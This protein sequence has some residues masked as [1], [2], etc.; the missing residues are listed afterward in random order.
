M[1]PGD[2]ESGGMCCRAFL[3]EEKGREHPIRNNG[4]QEVLLEVQCGQ[5]CNTAHHGEQEA[6]V[7]SPATPL[8]GSVTCYI[9]KAMAHCCYG[10]LDRG[11]AMQNSKHINKIN[12]YALIVLPLSEL[13]LWKI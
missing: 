3:E 8:H 1:E 9:F 6:N 12:D 11:K 13:C 10:L 4:K 2:K 7:S 5:G